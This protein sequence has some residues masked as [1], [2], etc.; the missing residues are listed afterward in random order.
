MV[1]GTSLADRDHVHVVKGDEAL[2]PLVPKSHAHTPEA[3]E[4]RKLADG[5]LGM[6][7]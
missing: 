4:Q 5:E 6:I 3:L 1:S 2:P 7:P